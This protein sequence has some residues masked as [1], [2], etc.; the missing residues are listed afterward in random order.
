MVRDIAEGHILVNER[1][2]TR[3]KGEEME[4][5]QFELTRRMRSVRGQQPALDA[6]REVQNRQRRLQRLAG[7]RRIL[8]AYQLRTRR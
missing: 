3:L 2:F 1:T 7:A 4:K 6:T 8:Q 5:L